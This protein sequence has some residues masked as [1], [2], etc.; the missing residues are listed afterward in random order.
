MAKKNQSQGGSQKPAAQAERSKKAALGANS[1]ATAQSK[2]VAVPAPEKAA[3]PVPPAPPI[4]AA[5]LTP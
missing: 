5:A 2:P 1:P 4:A 3:S